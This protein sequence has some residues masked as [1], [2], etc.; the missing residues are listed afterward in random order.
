MNTETPSEQSPSPTR[1]E[2]SATTPKKGRPTRSR[3]EAV[4][5]RRTPL[6]PKDRKEAKRRSKQKDR[7][8]ANREHQ[9]LLAGDEAHYP[10][11]HRGADRRLVRDIV[12]SRH[13]VAEYFLPFALIAMLFPFAMQLIDPVKF[14]VVSIVFLVVLWAGILVVVID[15]FL[16][17]R[18]IRKVLT[19]RFGVVPAGMVSYG[20]LRSTNIRPWRMPKPQIKHGEAPRP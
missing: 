4:A 7:A 6:V 16:L 11:Q 20:L 15:T 5:A 19:E 1:A 12:D 8:A 17:R 14:Q 13:N 18:K 9:A 3:K 10:L 2:H